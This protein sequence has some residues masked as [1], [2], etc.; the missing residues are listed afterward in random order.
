MNIAGVNG[1]MGQRQIVVDSRSLFSANFF[2]RILS[3]LVMA[4]LAVGVVLYGKLAFVGVTFLVGV[5]GLREWVRMVEPAAGPWTLAMACFAMVFGC[6]FT[7][8]AGYVVPGYLAICIMYTVL[9]LAFKCRSR[10]GWKIPLTLGGGLVYM[11]LFILSILILGGNPQFWNPNALLYLLVTVWAT[12]IGAYV[13]GRLI[14]GPKLAP[15]IS[16]NKTWAGLLGGMLLA[17]LCGYA[18]SLYR[19]AGTP[20]FAGACALPL[21]LL[22]Q[23]GDLV[24]SAVKRKCNVKDS[25]HLI[26]GH[27]GVLDRIDGLVFAAMAMAAASLL[28]FS[29]LTPY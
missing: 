25:G 15:V 2:Y 21:A 11:G 14:G 10:D 16:P 7:A 9:A 4:P 6:F 26:P 19:D 20:W 23:I 24:E 29:P 27:G 3:A 13:A 8:M 17:A 1:V 5:L 18:F 22:A 28:D 12:D